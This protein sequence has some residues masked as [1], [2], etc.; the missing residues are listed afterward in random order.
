MQVTFRSKSST[1]R[2]AQPTTAEERPESDARPTRGAGHGAQRRSGSLGGVLVQPPH[3]PHEREA[4]RAADA[5]TSGEH[6]PN[7]AQ[8]SQR[9][10]SPAPIEPEIGA[11]LGTGTPLPDA[12]AAEMG[13]RMGTDFSGVRVHT[14]DAAAAA[15]SALDADAFTSGSH[16]AFGRGR[17]NPET[18]D[19]KRLIAHELAH[20]AEGRSGIWRQPAGGEAGEHKNIW[21]RT[22]EAAAAPQPA[23]TEKPTIWDHIREGTM[24]PRFCP[25]EG[26]RARQIA[27][28]GI[29]EKTRQ[30]MT[31][32]A[33]MAKI[34][35]DGNE[36]TSSA[37][38]VQRIDDAIHQQFGSYISG[39]KTFSAA[40]N[41]PTHTSGDRS[42]RGLKP[43]EFAAEVV[44]DE[45]AALSVIA[46]AAFGVD[47]AT[48]RETCTT[49]PDDQMLIDQVA[50]PLLTEVGI[51]F[52]RNYRMQTLAGLTTFRR[53]ETSPEGAPNV[54]FQTSNRNIGTVILHE[55][56]HFYVHNHYRTGTLDRPDHMELM[57]GGA[58]H[59]TRVV[60]WAQFPNDPDFTI[61]FHT[62]TNE[63][64][65]IRRLGP[66]V[67]STFPTIYFQGRID[68]LPP[69]E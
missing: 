20:V 13:L 10:A 35:R 29:R 6:V 5:A 66:G 12:V 1:H 50:R 52:V 18:N 36:R 45:D 4:Q 31:Y 69:A 2:A 16:V 47:R 61:E 49:D 21:Q 30:R 26:E 41:S 56:L 58:E 28:A 54:M 14:G 15:S 19:G 34:K 46:R 38:L 22:R 7:R 57:E 8:K 24:D 42:V 48:M 17:Y 65:Y 3:H 33:G 51:D 23:A 60:I 37:D 43:D 27:I 32:D 11:A 59:L 63:V 67:L 64:D 9:I 44:P 55:A 25:D 62:Y 53:K 39:G 68:L 40:Y